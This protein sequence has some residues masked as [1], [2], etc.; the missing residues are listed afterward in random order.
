ME[1]TLIVKSRNYF[2]RK[3]NLN[4]HKLNLFGNKFY[5]NNDKCILK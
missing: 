5:F 2:Y 4:Y 1:N 3:D